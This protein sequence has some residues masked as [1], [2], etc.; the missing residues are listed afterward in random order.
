MRQTR[1]AVA[2]LAV[3]PAAALFTAQAQAADSLSFGD[4]GSTATFGANQIVRIDG[5]NTSR[6]DCPKPGINDFFYPATDVYIVPSGAES[7]AGRG[8][9]YTL[10]YVGRDGAGNQRSCTTTVTVPHV[11]TG[12]SA[13]RA[14]RDVMEARRRYA[15]RLRGA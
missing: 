8:R 14:T 15:A 10:T 13:A 9:V 5:S 12:V 11:C 3:M 6:N 7:A 2:A 1:R 4:Q